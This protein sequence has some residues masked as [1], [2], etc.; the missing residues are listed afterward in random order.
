MTQKQE[1]DYFQTYFGQQLLKEHSLEEEGS[2]EV[3][4]EDPNCLRALRRR[5]DGDRADFG[6]PHHEPKLGIY[7][8]KL[9]DVIALAVELPGFWAWGGGGRI[10][11]YKPPTVTRVAEA[12]V[13][14]VK[15]EARIKALEAELARL[16]KEL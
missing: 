5:R 15:K 1:K 11:A 4:G 14:R 12:K 9:G 2:W 6:G 13:S 8:G 7:S 10:T 16:K 3:F